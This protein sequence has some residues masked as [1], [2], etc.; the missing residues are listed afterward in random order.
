MYILGPI[1]VVTHVSNFVK[2]YPYE[3]FQDHNWIECQTSL[4]KILVNV[5]VCISYGSVLLPDEKKIVFYVVC[6]RY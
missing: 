4:E 6:T 1:H 3:V 2:W 5:H